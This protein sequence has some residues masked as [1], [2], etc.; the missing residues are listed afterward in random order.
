MRPVLAALRGYWEAGGFSPGGIQL[1]AVCKE[2]P[3]E[4]D[5]M[6]VAT[7]RALLAGD[8]LRGTTNRERLSEHASRR[9]GCYLAG[10]LDFAELLEDASR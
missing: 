10:S 1:P 2:T 5:G 7:F 9:H 3:E 6:V 4:Q 8:Y